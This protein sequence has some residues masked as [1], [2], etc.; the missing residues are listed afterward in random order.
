MPKEVKR[1]GESTLMEVAL[2]EFDDNQNAV[3]MPRHEGLDIQL[4]EKLVYVFLDEC[5]DRYAEKIGAKCVAKYDSL[6]KKYPIYVTEIRGE[7]IAFCQAP[8]GAPAATMVMDWLIGYG[9]KTILA[10]GCCGA[11][12]Y[13][14]ENV[15]LVPSK[16]LRDEGTSFHYVPPSRFIELDDKMRNLIKEGMERRNINYRECITWSTDAFFRETPAKIE[17]RKAEGCSVVDMEC[18]ALTACARFRGADYGQIIFTA[19]SLVDLDNY[20]VRGWGKDS[21]VKALELCLDL[22]R[23]F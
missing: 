9:C 14:D 2:V 7:E 4:P 8:V 22:I 5:I 16:A 19:D 3:I 10:S 15:F 11:L 1:P 6:T 17:S 18:S 13:I 23:D 21:F 20:D 12:E